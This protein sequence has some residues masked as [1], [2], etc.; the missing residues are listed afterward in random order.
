M[1][2]RQKQLASRWAIGTAGV[3]VLLGTLQK[4]TCSAVGWGSEEAFARLCYS[5]VSGLY[6][7]RGLGALSSPFQ[8]HLDSYGAVEYPTGMWV[9][10][11]A[12]AAVTHLVSG[13]PDVTART[14]L[15][16]E[17]ASA[18]A[19][20]AAE[21]GT[22]LV[23]TGAVCALVAALITRAVVRIQPELPLGALWAWAASPLLLFTGLIN[24]DLFAVAATMS[25]VLAVRQ[26]RSVW[27]GIWIGAGVSLKL[28]PGLVLVALGILALRSR[29]W[30]PLLRASLAAAAAWLAINL[31]AYL[32]SREAWSFFWR[33]GSER[34]P[35]M[36]SVWQALRIGGYSFP[37]PTINTVTIVLLGVLVLVVA[38]LGVRARRP[39]SL[40]ALAFLLVLGF[41][42]VNK[43]YSPQ[44]VLWLL[45][46]AVLAHPRVRDLV[47]WQ[48]GEA[49][50]AV[51]VMLH[52]GG[53]T[54][55][56]AGPD[57]IYVASIGLRL[58]AES[59][60]ALQVVRRLLAEGTD[61]SPAQNREG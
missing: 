45:P 20:L 15:T 32:A 41:A 37:T 47:I 9:V 46:L 42:A 8:P 28:Y 12:L 25:A 56:A 6:A 38:A 5:D 10:M 53:V 61:A 36:G 34:P 2:S 23:I 30:R 51:V 7:V 21:A 1:T 16:A 60:F 50:Y 18:A 52:I 44:Y 14:H 33:F 24:W 4:L 57:K 22:Y 29:Q 17:Q 49:V 54:T 13:R 11:W 55:P 59:W 39:P 26:G 19:D 27:A 40:A 35:H 43:V 31:P 58:L 3:M 48:V